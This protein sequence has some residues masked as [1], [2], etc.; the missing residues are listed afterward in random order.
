MKRF[1]VQMILQTDEE[2]TS[3]VE[4]ESIVCNGLIGTGLT[5]EVI[6]VLEIKQDKGVK[7]YEKKIY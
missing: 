7:N 1:I 5:V 4:T 6:Q 2:D 3:E